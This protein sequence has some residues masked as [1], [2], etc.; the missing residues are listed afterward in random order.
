MSTLIWASNNR[1]SILERKS[2]FPPKH[3]IQHLFKESE[4]LV[5]GAMALSGNQTVL[6]GREGLA[7]RDNSSWFRPSRSCV[8]NAEEAW[9]PGLTADT[10]WPSRSEPCRSRRRLSPACRICTLSTICAVLPLPFLHKFS[11]V[12]GYKTKCSCP[13]TEMLII[14]CPPL[15]YCWCW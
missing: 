2:L 14:W 12:D 7:S 3:A 10:L 9:P 6:H 15:F 13:S 8:G 1:K 5:H 4:H 11:N